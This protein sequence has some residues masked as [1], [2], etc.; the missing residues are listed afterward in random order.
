MLTT[1]VV[2]RLIA[3]ILI[4]H[5][6]NSQRETSDLR[7]TWQPYVAP[8]LVV[9]RKGQRAQSLIKLHKPVLL[10]APDLELPANQPGP[11]YLDLY[12]CVKNR[13]FADLSIYGLGSKVAPS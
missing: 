11:G 1:N 6:Q 9:P 10:S 8:P 4:W 5:G 7:L 2:Q 13:F 12:V 3:D